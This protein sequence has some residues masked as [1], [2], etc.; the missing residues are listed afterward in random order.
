MGTLGNA[1]PGNAKHT[2]DMKILKIILPAV[3]LLLAS[4]HTSRQVEQSASLSPSTGEQA[5]AAYKQK[6]ASNA[7][8]SATLTARVKMDI[9]AGG[10]DISVSG[11][12]RMKRDDV[13]QLSLTLF[14]VEVGRLEFTPAEVLIVDRFNKQYVRASY[15]QVGF[16][17]QAG[18][19]FYAVQA[20][21]WNELF[22]P[23]ERHAQ[24]ALQRFRV[25]A[26]GDHTLLSLPDAPKLDYA[27]LTVTKSGLIDR[28]TVQAKD[29][30]Q[31]GQLVWR[32]ADFSNFVGKPFP[33]TMNA[34]L[35]GLDK[36]AGFSLSLTRLGSSSDWETR[37]TVSG[38]YKQRK[39]E[40]ILRKLLTM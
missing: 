28:V 19:D 27:F 33:T 40:E 36:D 39:P 16:L 17:Q 29:V 31:R 35:S 25:S 7:S 15:D 23:G 10:R 18:L 1:N 37:T 22:V 38:K 20:L 21:F 34:S 4:C 32:Y 13:V 2:P 8:K 3:L 9:N 24:E 14:G 12:L 30:S 5:A 26:S 11:N 6:V